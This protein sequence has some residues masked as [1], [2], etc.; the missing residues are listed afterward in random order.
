WIGS[1]SWAIGSLA[2][3]LPV[4][5]FY[6][7]E[8]T[9]KPGWIVLTGGALA[10]TLLLHPYTFFAMAPPMLVL[11]VRAVRSG[12]SFREHAAVWAAALVAVLANL[13]WLRV[14]FR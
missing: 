7:W 3:V 5:L 14:A 9:R 2:S 6:R 1:L 4:G 12:L 13:Y 8:R 11:Y 10:T